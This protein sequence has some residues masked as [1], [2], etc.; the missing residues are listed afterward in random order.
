MVVRTIKVYT[1]KV[2]PCLSKYWYC[3]KVGEEFDCILI[4]K[5]ASDTRFRPMFAIVEKRG[6]RYISPVIVRTIRPE[7]CT[8]IK[9]HNDIGSGIAEY[10]RS[11]AK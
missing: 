11:F 1:V 8:I 4:T 7:D 6:D 3:S 10:R 2:E 9:E 5:E